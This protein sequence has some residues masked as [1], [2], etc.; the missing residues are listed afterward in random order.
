MKH[1]ILPLILASIGMMASMTSSAKDVYVYSPTG[2]D[3]GMTANVKRIVFDNGKMTLVP[4][5]GENVN[6]ELSDLGCFSFKSLDFSGISVT[7]NTGITVTMNGDILSVTSNSEISEI[8]VFNVFG[9]MTDHCSPS[10]NEAT[11][12]IGTRG[13]NIVLVTAGGITRTYKIAR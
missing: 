1:I 8:R 4:E 11:M 6:I 9:I 2:T 5:R 7:E 10:A 3:M 13:V 12:E